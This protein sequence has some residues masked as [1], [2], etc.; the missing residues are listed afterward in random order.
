MTAKEKA[1]K[2]VNSFI[3]LNS[4]KMSDYSRIE[5][6]T[7]KQCS[8]ITVDELI[9]YSKVHGFIGLTE[10]YKEVKNEIEKL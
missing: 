7:A 8:L 3:G 5:Y 6:P 1:E 2:L 4:K 9:N 10:Y